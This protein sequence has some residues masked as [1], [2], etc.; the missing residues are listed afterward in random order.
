MG[1]GV[2][3]QYHFF[4]SVIIISL[5][6]LEGP[7]LS[8]KIEFAQQ[9]QCIVITFVDCSNLSTLLLFIL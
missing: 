8:L 1:A 6:D 7:I 2:Q 3:Y 4:Y 9:F 5:F